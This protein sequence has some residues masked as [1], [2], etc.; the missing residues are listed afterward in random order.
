MSRTIT[1]SERPG[2]DGLREQRV[3]VDVVPC[4]Q[5]IGVRRGDARP[6]ADELRLALRVAA[7]RP[8]EGVDCARGGLAVHGTPRVHQLR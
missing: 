2:E 4:E 8:Q 1:R 6:R 7:Q 5:L 3:D